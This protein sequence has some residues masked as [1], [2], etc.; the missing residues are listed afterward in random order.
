MVNKLYYIMQTHL[1]IFKKKKKTIFDEATMFINK[2]IFIFK[3]T[4]KKKIKS[5]I[6]IQ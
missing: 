3:I 6:C 2:Y 4:K 1:R 5:F